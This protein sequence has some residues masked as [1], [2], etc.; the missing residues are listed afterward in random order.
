MHHDA[1]HRHVAPVQR[2]NELLHGRT[3]TAVQA[4]AEHVCLISGL[5]MGS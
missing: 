3:T 1:S 2:C 5:F 4:A